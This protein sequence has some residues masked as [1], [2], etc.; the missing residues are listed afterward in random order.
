MKCR[1]DCGA[2]CIVISISSPILGMPGG[3]PAGISCI[4]LTPDY[5]CD[6][7][8]HP[9]RP[10]VCNTFKAEKIICGDNRDEAMKLLRE[11]EE[12]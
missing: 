11:L 7:F 1:S 6:I 5:R 9:D 8:Y 12:N 2:C 10:K 3:K 4:H